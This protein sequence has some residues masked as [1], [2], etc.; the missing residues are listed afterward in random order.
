M[1][2]R[3]ENKKNTVDV[4]TAL[5]SITTLVIFISSSVYARREYSAPKEC[6]LYLAPSSI[7][8][9]GLG[10]YAGSTEYEAGSLI[11]D[12]D[13]MI[14]TWDLDYHNGNDAYYHLW[15]EY[16]WSISKSTKWGRR[17]KIGKQSFI[18]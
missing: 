14:P 9:A 15:D 18:I 7:P 16:T 3:R 6:G 17:G 1:L 5:L 11:S 8:G 4:V 12:G 10:M 13:L 2:L